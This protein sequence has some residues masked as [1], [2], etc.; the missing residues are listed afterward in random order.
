MPEVWVY[1]SVDA[2]EQKAFAEWPQG[3]RLSM[4]SYRSTLLFAFRSDKNNNFFTFSKEFCFGKSNFQSRRNSVMWIYWRTEFDILETSWV[5]E[6]RPRGRQY[7]IGCM[8]ISSDTVHL[9]GF[10]DPVPAKLS[11]NVN[12]NTKDDTRRA[13]SFP[14]FLELHRFLH[15]T[16]WKEYS[17]FV[18]GRP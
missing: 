18:W 10:Q 15:T 6:T 2:G 17:H 16:W 1:K 12:T 5:E 3:I 8:G 14:S 13:I 4:A 11:D 9:P 7:R